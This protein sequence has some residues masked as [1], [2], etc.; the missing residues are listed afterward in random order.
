MSIARSKTT[1]YEASLPRNAV[2]KLRPMA[3]VAYAWLARGL[4]GIV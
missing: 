1:S 2:H 4:L 3:L